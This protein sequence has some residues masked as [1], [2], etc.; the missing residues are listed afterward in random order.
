MP[1]SKTVHENSIIRNVKIQTRQ[2]NGLVIMGLFRKQNR[3]LKMYF[4]LILGSRLNFRGCLPG[5]DSWAS[6]TGLRTFFSLHMDY[7]ST[8][9]H[10]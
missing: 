3:T 6:D 5:L 4:L 7:P 10:Y 8:Y 9:L 1:R 2:L